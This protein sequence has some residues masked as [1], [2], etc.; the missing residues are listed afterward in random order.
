M[1]FYDL[2]GTTYDGQSNCISLIL[3]PIHHF[4][5][6]EQCSEQCSEHC[7]EQCSEQ[8]NKTR[9]SLCCSGRVQMHGCELDEMY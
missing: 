6:K 1:V 5:S 8:C 4:L 7:S 3:A 2:Q 9:V